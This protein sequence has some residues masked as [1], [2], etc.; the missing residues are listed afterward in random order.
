MTSVVGDLFD[1][2]VAS[3]HHSAN[4]RGGYR[5]FWI[6]FDIGY[7]GLLAKSENVYLNHLPI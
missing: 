4:Y 6:F 3:V 5:G 7:R 2:C 1:R